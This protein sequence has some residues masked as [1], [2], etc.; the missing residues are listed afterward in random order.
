ML[1]KLIDLSVKLIRKYLPDPFVFAIILTVVAGLAAMFCTGQGALEVLENWG[2]GVWSLLAFSMQMALVLVCGSALADAPLIKR[3]LRKMAALPKTPAAAITTVTLVASIACWINWGFG[4]IVGAIFAK[5]IARAVKGVDYRLLIAAAYSG[6]VV[7][8]A[9]LSASIPLAMATDGESLVEVS[10]GAITSA[11]PISQT[12]FATYNLIIVF[13]VIVALTAVNT[14]MHPVPE[15][16]FIVDPA[17]LGDGEEIKEEPLCGPSGSENC[18]E[19]RASGCA[20]CG[21]GKSEWKMSPSEKLNNSVVLGGL[22]ALMGLGYLVVKIVLKGASLDLNNVIMLFMFLGI[23]LHKTPIKYV[24]AVTASA[25]SSAG[26]LLQ[27]PFYAGIMGIMTSAGADGVSLAGQISEACV[28]MSNEKTFPLLSFLSAGIVNV[29]VPSGGG[30]W[31]VQ[32]PIMLPAGV[33][34]GVDPAVT[35]MAIAWGDAWTNLIQ[36]FWAL[37]ALAIAKLDAK[38]IMGFCLIDLF[39]VGV[40][41]CAGFLFLV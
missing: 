15:K 9:G 22:V 39:I 30:Q 1:S 12:I 17:L 6:F 16:A 5:E 27:F 13:V 8:H 31:A 14:L 7:W 25:S 4:L 37:P 18:E 34:L 29:F 35:G 20:S 21:E 2:G 24:K 26:I 19:V 32:A 3:G 11:I 23:V 28:A 10:R 38:D 33:Q 40:I 41:V 36:P